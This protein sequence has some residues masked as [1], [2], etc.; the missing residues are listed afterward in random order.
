[1][2]PVGAGEWLSHLRCEMLLSRSERD[3]HR[4]RKCGQDPV[5]DPLVYGIISH[6]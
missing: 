6:R 3:P 2:S 1:M 4:Q 5:L